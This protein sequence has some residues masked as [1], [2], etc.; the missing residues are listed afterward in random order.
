MPIV[1]IE[2]Y[3]RAM[4]RTFVPEMARGAHAILQYNFTGSQTGGCYIIVEDG[5]LWAAAGTHPTPT[6]AVTA[7]FDLWLRITSYE[8]DGLLSY[9]EGLYSI[10]GDDETLMISDTWFKRR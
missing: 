10:A 6:A 8:L 2:D 1:T 3:I 5:A 9:Q 4:E 7:D